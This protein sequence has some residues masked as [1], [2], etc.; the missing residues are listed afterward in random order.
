M[1]QVANSAGSKRQDNQK[2]DSSDRQIRIAFL[3]LAPLCM[4]MVLGWNGV[5][6]LK[7]WPTRGVSVLYWSLVAPILWLL[8]YAI[9]ILG[10]RIV[11]A[12][13]TGWRFL[14]LNF[15][16][17]FVALNLYRPINTYFARAYG[18]IFELSV[19]RIAH[20]WPRDFGNFLD[21]QIAYLPFLAIWIL[22]VLIADRL[23]ANG[24][25]TGKGPARTALQEPAS[26]DPLRSYLSG[27]V[28]GTLI[29][30]SA[31][32]H[33]VRVYSVGDN[34]RF[35][36]RFADALNVL[37]ELDGQRIHRSHWVARD[38]MC[39]LE[40]TPGKSVLVLSDGRRLPVSASYRDGIVVAVAAV[41]SA[42]PR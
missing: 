18:R 42:R 20:P 25:L 3:V 14:L 32:D 5:G 31:E 6:M 33:Y 22:C 17:V 38:H 2:T 19:D 37:G 10:R 12:P 24:F 4:A 34:V 13:V 8:T 7:P 15:V 9:F 40:S 39:D 41:C 1:C 35:L 23:S 29:S 30:V 21:W 26:G 28:D 27:I 36:Y 11:V 16:S